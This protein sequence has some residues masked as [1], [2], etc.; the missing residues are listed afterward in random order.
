MPSS[1]TD[2]NPLALFEG[3]GVEIEEMVVDA[4][5]LD[6]RPGADRALV[7][8]DGQVVS[9][10]PRGVVAWCNELSAHVI[11]MKNDGP[12]PSLDGL[13][14]EF[15]RSVRDIGQRLA[16]HGLRLM[17]TGMHP[18]MD[19]MREAVLWPHECSEVY[20]AFDRIFDCRGHGWSNLQSVQINLP[21]ADD[22]EFARLHAA[23]R[24]LLP[25]MPGLTAST[26]FVEGVATGRRDNRMR[27]Y[28]ANCAKIPSITGRVVPEVWRDRAGYEGMLSSIHRDLAPFDPERILQREWVNARGAIARFDRGAIEIRILDTQECPAAD[29]AVLA[30]ITG[31]LRELVVGG[32]ID[33]D[34]LD[35]FET[36]ELAGL[37]ETVERDGDQAVIPAG[38]YL[39]VL[40]HGGRGAARAGEVWEGLV[41]RHLGDGARDAGL[42]RR[43]VAAI[44]REGCLARRIIAAT[45]STP[46]PE[47]L[48][49]VFRSL[50]DHLDAGTVFSAGDV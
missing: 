16:P 27:Y 35:R 22:E 36:E 33:I 40:G 42:W 34:A 10:V 20:G 31:V 32:R 8:D 39:E 43:H 29:I 46:G 4:E 47:R 18:W 14:A 9:D 44:A 15:Q 21:F 23:I 28:R 37:L 24:F 38:A 30:A 19:P 1:P 7:D 41:E 17:P 5:T 48:R 50:C 13:A 3:F 49:D 6:V 26:P 45:G 25:L 12:A 2:R 11:E